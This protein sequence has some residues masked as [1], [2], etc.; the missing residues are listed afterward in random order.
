MALAS[1]LVR[2]DHEFVD[3]NAALAAVLRGQL[4]DR[5]DVDGPSLV[6]CLDSD[7]TTQIPSEVL[8]S[9]SISR[10]VSIPC[11]STMAESSTVSPFGKRLADR[12]TSS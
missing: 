9:M 2:H 5:L 10:F 4:F 1:L 3:L 6:F 11:T 12:L 7:F 8:C